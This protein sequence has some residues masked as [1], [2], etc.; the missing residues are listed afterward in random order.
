M[1][2]RIRADI[3]G[4]FIDFCAL[5][6]GSNRLESLKVLTT[7]D[8]PGR[9]LMHGLTRLQ[10]EHGVDPAAIEAFVHG[11]TIGINTIIQRKGAKLGL[12]TTAGFEDVIELARLRLPEMYSL[13]C[14]RPEPLISRDLVFGVP[15]RLLADGTEAA[16]LDEDALIAAVTRMKDKKV[17]GI[18]IAF[19]HAYRSD[20][21]ERR[22][23]AV[24]ENLAPELFVFTSSEV[25]PV[26]REYERTTTAILNGYVHPRVAGYLGSLE[27]APRRRSVP[28]RAMITKSNGGIMNVAAGKRACASMLLSGTA[29]GVM[30]ASYL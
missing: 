3:G 24:I 8:E 15:E 23:Q 21:H 11:T 10:R 5:E 20:A 18:I 9:E 25:W 16:A 4:P 14:A 1:A 28:A 22:A 27:A 7:P 2:W 12:V 29:S 6:I 17:A 30:G 19:L 13:F 26:I